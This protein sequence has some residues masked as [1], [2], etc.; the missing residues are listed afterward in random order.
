LKIR[1]KAKN[2]IIW[3]KCEIAIGASINANDHK[4]NK[5]QYIVDQ[6]YIHDDIIIEDDVWLGAYACI[7]KGATIKHG[8]IIGA[9]AVAT[10]S[11]HEYSINVGVPSKEI[12][13][14]I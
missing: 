10:K 2:I 5:N 4:H 12:R 7:N 6:G 11:T 13:K 9:S 8:S 14:R 3:K 1:G